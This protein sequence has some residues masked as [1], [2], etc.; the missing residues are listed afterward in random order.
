MTKE[1][2][3]EKVRKEITRLIHSYDWSQ[4]QLIELGAA[5]AKLDKVLN[6]GEKK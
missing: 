1:Q 4:D 2:D 3:F 6:M 5:R